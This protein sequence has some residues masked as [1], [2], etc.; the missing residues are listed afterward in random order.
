MARVVKPNKMSEG[1]STKLW[2]PPGPSGD[3]TEKPSWGIHISCTISVLSCCLSLLLTIAVA[4]ETWVRL[5]QALGDHRN[6]SRGRLESRI[7][8]I[9]SQES[10]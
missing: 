5:L 1:M 3:S 6:V 7:Q 2:H 8:C 4:R 10:L 9:S